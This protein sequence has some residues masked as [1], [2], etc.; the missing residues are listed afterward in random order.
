M[1][2]PKCHKEVVGDG[3]FCPHCGA[4]L[5]RS[6]RWWG[7]LSFVVAV[8]L[9]GVFISMGFLVRQGNSSVQTSAT[10]VP[11]QPMVATP[12]RVGVA[13]GTEKRDWFTWAVD[14][15][16]HTPQGAGIQI[17]LKPMGSL[18]AAQAI[19]HGDQSIQVWSPASSLYR[20]VFLRDWAAAN[21]GTNAGQNPVLSEQPL[22]LTPM[23]LVMWQQRY[24]AFMKHYPELSFSTIAQA[25]NE[26]GG[27]S[28]IANQPDWGFFKFSHTHPNH[29]NSGLVA[30]VLMAYDYQG[31]HRALDAEQI[32]DA[33]FQEWLVSTEQNQVG[34][35]SGL[36]D[37][38]GTLMTAMVQRGWSTYDC[39][40][41]YEANA[42]DRLRQANGRWGQL[43]V[44][45][46]KYN[47]WNDNPYV[48]LNVPWS[49]PE[50]RRAA[51][52][53][54]EFLLSESA[55]RE[56]MKHGFRPA[57][58]NVSTN[59]ADSPFVQFAS[60]GLRANVPGIFCEPPNPDALETL[61]LGWQ[62][63]QHA[64]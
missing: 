54:A 56:A 20:G 40:M 45:Y 46:P 63:S 58:V 12:I 55:Q 3:Q 14:A 26:P 59:G 19:V 38:T 17:D 32:T 60:V 49:T 25:M 47:F 6:G 18:E 21:L 36:I 15:F 62:R 35:A 33:K 50:Q 4:T 16:V 11:S 51:G 43:Q 61:L 29:S 7:V 2:C 41:V 30:L 5:P 13:Y 22:A 8:L 52:A 39:V 34:A 27:W 1:K 28:T 9:I 42:I 23:V 10:V 48:I 44:V 53:F 37:S 57:N 24:E 31:T 64:R